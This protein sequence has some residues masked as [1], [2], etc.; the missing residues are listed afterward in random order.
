MWKWRRK[1]SDFSGKS[2]RCIEEEVLRNQSE[3]ITCGTGKW[4]IINWNNQREVEEFPH[5]VLSGSRC[6]V[7]AALRCV[8]DGFV[9]PRSWLPRRYHVKD[10]AVEDK[11][12]PSD[13]SAA[14]HCERKL[15]IKLMQCHF[16]IRLSSCISQSACRDDFAS[17]ASTSPSSSSLKISLVRR[18]EAREAI[19]ST[20]WKLN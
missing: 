4:N 17:E 13:H 20:P 19:K 12:S 14:Q 8:A 5:S 6:R 18:G 3:G 2:R 11:A 9:N 7:R 16:F 1:K 15:L 10:D